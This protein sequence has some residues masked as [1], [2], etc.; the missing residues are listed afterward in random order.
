MF[1][2]P[3][4]DQNSVSVRT[5]FWRYGASLMDMGNALVGIKTAGNARMVH[6]STLLFR[7]DKSSLE[8][9]H[10]DEATPWGACPH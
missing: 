7:V 5:A 2:S 8:V 4:G 1:L 3:L 10:I 6:K 9:S